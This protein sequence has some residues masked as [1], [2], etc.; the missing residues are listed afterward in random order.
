[1]IGPDGIPRYRKTKKSTPVPEVERVAVPVPNAGIPRDW[2]LNARKTIAENEWVSN[3]GHRVWQ[4]TAGSYAAQSAARRWARTASPPAT[5][6][7]TA[8]PDAT[9]EG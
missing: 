6:S 8:A 4:L 7:T 2:V 9:T 5:A 1:V 3:A